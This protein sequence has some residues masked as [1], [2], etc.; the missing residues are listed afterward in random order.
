[1]SVGDELDCELQLDE[2]S[3]GAI[4][5]LFLN[6]EYNLQRSIEDQIFRKASAP[7]LAKSSMGRL[8]VLMSVA[9]PL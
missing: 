3:R 2:M 4:N 7:S 1:M 6:L 5:K 8:W 9:T